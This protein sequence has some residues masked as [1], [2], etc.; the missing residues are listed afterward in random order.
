MNMSHQGNAALSLPEPL[1]FGATC[2]QACYWR[3]CQR[4]PGDPCLNIAARWRLEGPIQIALMERAWQQVV[5]RH[6]VLRTE[7]VEQDG[8]LVQRVLPHAQFRIRHVDLRGA[9]PP[10]QEA[11]SE[12]LGREEAAAPFDPFRPPLL[13]ITVLQ[14]ADDRAHMLLTTHHLAGD[15]WAN[16]TLVREFAAICDALSLGATPHLPDPPMQFGD[17]ASWQN[18]WLAAGGAA[19]VEQYW[20]KRLDGLA[21]FM[22]PTDRAPPAHPTRRGDIFG[23]MV[24]AGVAEATLAAA[25]ARGATF[26]AFGLA[27]FAALLHRWSGHQDILVTTQIAGRDELEL[28]TVVGPFINTLALRMACAPETRFADLLDETLATVGEALENGALPFEKLTDRITLPASDRRGALHGVNFQVLN[29]AFLKD[30]RAGAVA[31]RGFPS[32]SPG[33]KRDLDVYLVEREV[34][35]RAQCEYDPDLFDEATVAWVVRSFVE[36]LAAVSADPARTLADLPFTPP[37]GAPSG[38]GRRLQSAAAR[39]VAVDVAA[40]EVMDSASPDAPAE[41]NSVRAERLVQLWRAAVR[42]DDPPPG[43]S[44]FEL[45]GDSMRAARLVARIHDAF[46]QR[47]G[48]ARFFQNPTLAGLAERLGVELDSGPSAP[49]TGYGDDGDE[50]W[51]IMEVS[52]RGSRTPVIGVNSVETLF[53]LARDF[54]EDRH[55]FG[56]RLFEPGKPHGI[57]GKT[58]PE[59]AADY[60]EVIRAVEPKGPYILFGLCVHGVLALEIARQLRDAGDVVEMVCVVNAWH[61]TYARRLNFLN[62]QLVRLNDVSW[63]LRRVFRREKTFVEFLG[64]YRLAQASGLLQ[65]AVRLGLIDR[66]PT[67]TGSEFNDDFLLTLMQAR[68]ACE[69]RGVSGPVM[70]FLGP[71][72]P[73]WPGIDRTL[74]WKGVVNGAIHVHD[75]P[76]ARPGPDDPGVACIV[77]H[78]GRMIETGAARG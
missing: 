45:G 25:R 57:A 41:D 37:M 73:K 59:I 60:I 48:L 75:M 71:D 61:P 5:D 2:A 24:P 56:V 34:G 68:D 11:L 66:A 76:P 28:E 17:F 65:L 69:P 23:M 27:T 35:W 26:F 30:T 58:F 1:E 67:R 33:A 21:N 29:S 43:A 32:L 50:D 49:V 19:A 16:L 78:F 39:P 64:N 72:T 51:R 46:G 7:F 22:V 44:F 55:I 10:E 14:Q 31:L 70:Q 63:N 12:R 15:C 36:L 74:G 42:C 18:A 4:S 8:Q 54:G 62:R 77:T 6:E 9:P 40:V 47:V 20:I 52:P 3:R 38:A 13:R 53:A